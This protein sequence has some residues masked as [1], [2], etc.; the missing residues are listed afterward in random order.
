MQPSI[1]C[2]D[3]GK[4]GYLVISLDFFVYFQL[5]PLH[6]YINLLPLTSIITGNGRNIMFVRRAVKI[7]YKVDYDSYFLTSTTSGESC[8]LEELFIG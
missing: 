7:C 8:L 4:K 6:M 1:V 5:K 3:H 2:I